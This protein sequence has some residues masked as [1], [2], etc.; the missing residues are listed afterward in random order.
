MSC[1]YPLKQ[2]KSQKWETPF[3]AW[4]QS[5]LRELGKLLRC[6]RE[7]FYKAVMWM[8]ALSSVEWR[9]SITVC[10]EF[11]CPQ[12]S[13]DFLESGCVW[14]RFLVLSPWPH[15]CHTLIYIFHHQGSPLQCTFLGFTPTYS[16]SVVLKWV[17]DLNFKQASQM[18]LW[19]VFSEK[20]P[21]GNRTLGPG[22]FHSPVLTSS[23]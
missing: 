14:C 11:P 8:S 20:P 16:G 9:K 13:A 6:Y 2:V 19:K 15:T 5:H 23:G 4:F 10:R 18:T 1:L 3:K 17:Q 22:L 21:I 12:N 7:S